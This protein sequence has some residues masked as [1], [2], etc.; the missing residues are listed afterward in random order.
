MLIF[1]GYAFG[2][3]LFFGVTYAPKRR[4]CHASV[5]YLLKTADG[6]CW[7]RFVGQFRYFPLKYCE[8]IHAPPTEKGA[9]KGWDPSR[10]LLFTQNK[11]PRTRWQLNEIQ[12]RR[13]NACLSNQNTKKHPNSFRVIKKK[14]THN[15]LVN[16]STAG[17]HCDITRTYKKCILYSTLRG[18]RW[19]SKTHKPM[20]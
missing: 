3:A 6:I 17:R 8:R 15:H 4:L 2:Y 18:S 10:M 5:G 13:R 11:A 7:S 14:H 1:G 20:R 9:K 19:A 12:H 16:K